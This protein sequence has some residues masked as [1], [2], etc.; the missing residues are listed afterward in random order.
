M[1]LQLSPLKELHAR[2]ASSALTSPA[3]PARA[4]DA[5]QQHS[6][7]HSPHAHQHAQVCLPHRWASTPPTPLT[8]AESS[9]AVAAY[10]TALRETLLAQVAEPNIDLLQRLCKQLQLPLISLTS[11]ELIREIAA[12]QQL[13][14]SASSPKPTLTSPPALKT[15]SVEGGASQHL[16]PVQTCLRVLEKL[17]TLHRLWLFAVHQRARGSAT[18][19]SSGNHVGISRHVIH[20]SQAADQ[21]R[22]LTRRCVAADDI[23]DALMSLADSVANTSQGEAESDDGGDALNR[24]IPL[25]LVQE[26]L[27]VFHIADSG[28][29]GG[30]ETQQLDTLLGGS[31]SVPPPPASPT[32]DGGAAGGGVEG[33][34]VRIGELIDVLLYSNANTAV[35]PGDDS[36]DSD[37]RGGGVPQFLASLVDTTVGAAPHGATAMLESASRYPITPQH[38]APTLCEEL[39]RRQQ[40]LPDDEPQQLQRDGTA[41]HQGDVSNS[42]H[43]DSGMRGDSTGA[44]DASNGSAPGG[45]PEAAHSISPPSRSP[46]PLPL[47]AVREDWT[48]KP[49]ASILTS[50]HFHQTS[51]SASDRQWFLLS[52]VDVPGRLDARQSSDL[53]GDGSAGGIT[54][55]SHHTARRL[56]G[57]LSVRAGSLTPVPRAP[58]I[59]GGGGVATSSIKAPPAL[60][61]GLPP[62]SPLLTRPPSVG[63]AGSGGATKLYASEPIGVASH[64][65]LQQAEYVRYRNT[66]KQVRMHQFR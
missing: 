31:T 45:S 12:Q 52:E 40:R 57:R 25:R 63:N 33:A 59:S 58:S 7:Y 39:L 38:S 43:M 64:H 14:P 55:R 47:L 35:T 65:A 66:Y 18:N 6:P 54:R 28:D 48:R 21:K 42:V 3:L 32:S 5:P 8:P 60:V 56:T 10:P 11:Q 24:T 19:S 34:R 30:L 46:P 29:S 9:L 23:I 61:E 2:S 13:S 26:V 53:D 37:E 50:A 36:G 49:P 1:N 27:A 44:H 41:I 4:R 16:L 17:K 15:R 62:P 51:S 22:H 20:F